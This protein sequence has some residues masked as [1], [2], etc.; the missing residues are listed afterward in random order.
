MYGLMM[1]E[2]EFSSD[3]PEEDMVAL[4]L[5]TAPDRKKSKQKT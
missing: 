1:S 2:K 3:E 5:G 4:K